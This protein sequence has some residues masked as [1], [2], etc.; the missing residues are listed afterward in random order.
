MLW[1]SNCK[2]LKALCT[3]FHL[4]VGTSGKKGGPIKQDYI[5]AI[6]EYMASQ[7]PLNLEGEDVAMAETDHDIVMMHARSIRR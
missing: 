1:G 3:D 7:P 2:V 5:T 4:T 6:I